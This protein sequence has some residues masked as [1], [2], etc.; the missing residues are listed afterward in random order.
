MAWIMDTYSMH[1]GYTI[2]GVVTGK[3]IAIGGSLGRNEATGPRCGLHA[4]PVG[5]VA[6]RPLP[7]QRVSI[8]GYGKRRQHRRDAA[9][10]G[11]CARSSR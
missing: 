8:Q 10:R 4:A 9:R 1:H 11:G 6:N 2:A 3:P 7:G 5:E